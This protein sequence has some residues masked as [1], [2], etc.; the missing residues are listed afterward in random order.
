MDIDSAASTPIL[1]FDGDLSKVQYLK[2]ELTGLAYHLDGAPRDGAANGFS[3][4][5]IGP[6]RRTRPPTA[7]LFGATRVDGVEVNPIIADDVMLGRFREFSWIHLSASG[8]Q[9]RDRTTD[10]ASSGGRANATT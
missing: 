7:L 2:Y 1:K 4:L 5:V 3:A 9:G 6:W 10:A 8:R